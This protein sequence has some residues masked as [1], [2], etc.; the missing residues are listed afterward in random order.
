MEER[1][2][3]EA[4]VSEDGGR[5]WSALSTVATGP[6]GMWEPFLWL[7]DAAAGQDPAV[8]WCAYSQE[9]TNGGLQSIALPWG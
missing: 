5:S 8:L 2:S 1:W 4:S 6:I 9:L 7:D 3:T